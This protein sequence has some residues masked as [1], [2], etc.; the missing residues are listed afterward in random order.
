MAAGKV[1]EQLMQLTKQIDESW[2]FDAPFWGNQRLFTIAM[3]GFLEGRVGDQL[4]DYY[5]NLSGSQYPFG[6]LNAR[7][8]YQ[9][10]IREA[11][12]EAEEEETEDVG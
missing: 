3:S 8:L 11:Q 10:S 2:Y 4:S 12:L 9:M 5:Q 6:Q 7:I 1:C